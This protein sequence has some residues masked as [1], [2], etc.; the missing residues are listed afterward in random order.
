MAS[1]QNYQYDTLNSGPS[2]DAIPFRSTE[3]TYRASG[4]ETCRA[5]SA[6]NIV[7]WQAYKRQVMFEFEAPL[8]V[9]PDQLCISNTVSTWFAWNQ[10]V[11]RKFFRCQVSLFF[12]ICTE[13]ILPK[14]RFFTVIWL[15]YVRASDLKKNARNYF[16]YSCTQATLTKGC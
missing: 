2:I 9:H 14:H 1:G 6:Y 15:V 11:H 3:F 13:T 5:D 7:F 10:K 16:A 12:I 4:V 8:D